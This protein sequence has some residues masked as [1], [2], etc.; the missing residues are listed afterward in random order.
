MHKGGLVWAAAAVVWALVMSF[1]APELEGCCWCSAATL[2]ESH[3][4]LDWNFAL[5]VGEALGPTALPMADGY[6][7]K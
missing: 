6:L 4:L 2:R 7:S 5:S 3:Q 1:A